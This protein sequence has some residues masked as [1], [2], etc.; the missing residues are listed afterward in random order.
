MPDALNNEGIS[1]Q[2]GEKRRIRGTRKYIR[3]LVEIWKEE[4]GA[5]RSA[6]LG[7]REEL[8]HE[9]WWTERHII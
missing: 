8:D 5:N 2:G 6:Y 1:E 4:G 3:E 7:T 9:Y